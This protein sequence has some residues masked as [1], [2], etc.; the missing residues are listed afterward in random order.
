[1]ENIRFNKYC[2]DIS[3]DDS[4]S[5][6]DE[7]VECAL[8]QAESMPNIAKTIE[9]AQR[10][11]EKKFAKTIKK[12]AK[13]AKSGDENKNRK[14]LKISCSAPSGNI[15]S[16]STSLDNQL[17]PASGY[18]TV[19]TASPDLISPEIVITN[20]L[21]TETT[22]LSNEKTYKIYSEHNPDTSN[23]P[24]DDNCSVIPP[25]RDYTSTI[26]ESK[27]FDLP[28]SANA[29]GSKSDDLPMN[30]LNHVNSAPLPLP[31]AAIKHEQSVLADIAS[32]NDNYVNNKLCKCVICE[33]CKYKSGLLKNSEN[34]TTMTNKQSNTPT[35]CKCNIEKGCNAHRKKTSIPNLSTPPS[36]DS[37]VFSRTRAKKALRQQRRFEEHLRKKNGQGIITTPTS[38]DSSFNGTGTSSTIKPK[39]I[40]LKH[41]VSGGLLNSTTLVNSEGKAMMQTT[42]P[43]CS[44]Y[45]VEENKEVTVQSPNVHVNDPTPGHSTPLQKIDSAS[46]FDD[47]DRHSSPGGLSD[48]SSNTSINVTYMQQCIVRKSAT[49]VF[50]FPLDGENSCPEENCDFVTKCRNWHGLVDELK[51]HIIIDHSIQITATSKFCNYCSSKVRNPIK[52]HAC[53][54]AHPAI[55][56][57]PPTSASVQKDKNRE[58]INPENKENIIN[59]P[60]S[61]TS[62]LENEDPVY[63]S[64][65]PTCMNTSSVDD[66]STTRAKVPNRLPSQEMQTH[67]DSP[68]PSADPPTEPLTPAND[69]ILVPETQEEKHSQPEGDTQS[70]KQPASSLSMTC[71]DTPDHATSHIPVN[72]AASPIAK[73]L[74]EINV[75]HNPMSTKEKQAHLTFPGRITRSGQTLHLV[76]P[77]TE[78]LQCTEGTCSKTFPER[79]WFRERIKLVDHLNAS[80]NTSI[81]QV[82]RWCSIC[83]LQVPAKV[84][85]HPCFK[86]TEFFTP[87][88]DDNMAPVKTTTYMASRPS[89]NNLNHFDNDRTRNTAPRFNPLPEILAATSNTLTAAESGIPAQLTNTDYVNIY[90]PSRST[91]DEVILNISDNSLED[92]EIQ[93]PVLLQMAPQDNGENTPSITVPESRDEIPY[94]SRNGNVINFVFPITSG[95]PCTDLGCPFGIT[96]NAWRYAREGIIQ[97]L[98]V[99]HKITN[100]ITKYWC[101]FCHHQIKGNLSEHPCFNNLCFY[102]IAEPDVKGD[103]PPFSCRK[104]KYKSSVKNDI[105]AHCNAHNAPTQSSGT[106]DLDQVVQLLNA[107]G[108][109]QADPNNVHSLPI[110]NKRYGDIVHLVFPLPSSL[111]CTETHTDCKQ[112]FTNKNWF[113]SKASLVRHLQQFHKL[114]INEVIGWCSHC[115][116]KTPTRV[117]THSCLRGG[118]TL[119]R[120]ANSKQ[121]FKCNKCDFSCSSKNGIMNHYRTHRRENH[122]NIRDHLIIR[123]R[124]DANRVPALPPPADLSQVPGS[125]P[126]DDT[127]PNSQPVPVSQD[128]GE[129]GG[130][131]DEEYEPNNTEINP[132]TTDDNVLPG[133]TEDDVTDPDRPSPSQEYIN[134]FQ[135]ILDNWDGFSWEQ[136]EAKLEAF[137]EFGQKHVNLKAWSEGYIKPPPPNPKDPRV[138]QKLYRNNRRRAIRLITENDTP[139]CNLTSDEITNHFCPPP[140][141]D[142]SP[143]FF[144]HPAPAQTPPSCDPFHP[145]EV[146]DRLRAAEN[147]S[148]GPDRLT[149][150]HLKKIDPGA[151]ALA[152]IFSICLKAHRVPAIWKVSRTVLIAKC[153][154][155]TTPSDWRPISLNN[156]SMKLFTGCLAKRITNWIETNNILT[157]NQKGFLPYDGCFENNYIINQLIQ[158]TRQHR[159]SLCLASLDISNAFGSVPHGAV[160]EAIRQAGIGDTYL[161]TVISLYTESS[162]TFLLEDGTSEPT[163]FRS[164]VRQGCPLSGLL[165]NFAIDPI[166]RHIQGEHPSYKALAYADDIILI[167]NDPESLQ[168]SISTATALAAEIGLNINPHKC[169]TIHFA[170]SPMG[171]K[172]TKF[173]VNDTTLP[174]ILDGN[175]ARFLG[176]PIGFNLAPDVQHFDKFVTLGEEV[177]QSKLAPWQSLDALKSFVYPSYLYAMRTGQYL[178]GDWNELDRH[179]RPHIKKTLSLPTRAANEYLYGSVEQGLFNIPLCAED[180]DIANIDGAFKLL[181]SKD[182]RTK[183]L[184]W[185]DIAQFIQDRIGEVPSFNQV[186]SFLSGAQLLG[187]TNPISTMWSRARAASTRLRVTW[188]VINQ[189]DVTLSFGDQS[190]KDRTEVFRALRKHFRLKRGDS[191]AAK[192]HQGKTFHCYS[193]S[194]S[195]THFHRAGD[196]TRFA[197]WRFIHAARLGLVPLNGY[198]SADDQLSSACRRCPYAQETLP[199]VICHCLTHMPEITARHNN[200]VERIKNAALGRWQLYSE[201]RPLAGHTVRPDLVLTKGNTALILDVTCPF[202]NGPNAFDVARAEK[203]RK[204]TPLASSLAERFDKVKV[205]AIVVGALGSWDPNND[206]VL[207]S[208]CSK[209]YLKL[210]R[211]LIVSTTIRATRNIYIKHISG[212]PQDDPSA[213]PPRSRY[214]RRRAPPAFNGRLNTT[215][216]DDLHHT[217]NAHASE[218]NSTR[219]QAIEFIDSTIADANNPEASMPLLEDLLTSH[220]PRSS[221]DLRD[222]I[223]PPIM[224]E[225]LRYLLD[226]GISINELRSLIAED[227]VNHPTMV[228]TKRIL[229]SNENLQ[230]ISNFSKTISN[231]SPTHATSMATA[232]VPTRNDNVH[233]NTNITVNSVNNK[234]SVSANAQSVT[235]NVYLPNP[236]LA[237]VPMTI[238]NTST[239]TA[240]VNT[241]T[242][243]ASVNTSTVTASVYSNANRYSI[244]A[245]VTIASESVCNVTSTCALSTMTSSTS[246]KLNLNSDNLDNTN[247]IHR[248]NRAQISPPPG[249][250]SITGSYNGL[251]PF[252]PCGNLANNVS[253]PSQIPTHKSPEAGSSA[254]GNV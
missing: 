221:Q 193:M 63:G 113:T 169:C 43:T 150:N 111:P 17:Q 139:R 70:V 101:T 141:P 206:A 24:V 165:F 3:S 216:D 233:N 168:E 118:T 175:F 130:D 89:G 36:G 95:L 61:L 75:S 128:V 161:Q 119:P 202:E 68:Q 26:A 188:Q 152:R 9:R 133:T 218:T 13:N 14:N 151:L 210:M 145:K 78:H 49:L 158:N 32:T 184:A 174:S 106:N 207:A 242:V 143:D 8:R 170:G 47:L 204:Y 186:A 181:T 241:S 148:P 250:A 209:K 65:R 1:M 124:N 22:G 195:S 33:T 142:P 48:A 28:T 173:K 99:R 176:K 131:D 87:T 180:S 57:P 217:D 45:T 196:F 136:F 74:H 190:T 10:R 234:P 235:A 122:E 171:C 39:P 226:S 251:P 105:L 15:D 38:K 227:P 237:R 79:S 191:L 81:T 109:S 44:L 203:I 125:P 31:N 189:D 69:E 249:F 86:N 96:S 135:N 211:K 231:D 254:S 104:C 5:S 144:A 115:G 73:P 146:W 236:V 29:S 243:T 215:P 80:H 238:V 244:T 41:F 91:T 35:M 21:T 103:P 82:R 18:T 123:R 110:G 182:P 252:T 100:P 153:E 93:H 30:G 20:P 159:D 23:I 92:F 162:T 107:E 117:A 212:I 71:P 154:Q 224:V 177:L 138:I 198:R 56:G 85:S 239:V 228:P 225:D 83:H 219:E 160:F 97:H 66:L 246:Q 34:V 77:I 112:T 94:Y 64:P 137:V 155:P 134:Y 157:Y 164:G 132:A 84:A 52:K 229:N 147:T 50:R 167:E 129:N 72:T 51:N 208:I 37:P 214:G 88:L 220:P 58:T 223:N 156:T 187:T 4:S 213:P 40:A 232:N 245:P 98:L 27:T 140:A 67:A 166:L 248:A 59:Q 230:A 179:F 222:L 197:E 201:N 55:L 42:T 16:G 172:D 185:C 178:K 247:Y 183:H 102:K 25:E 54:K 62:Q 2:I 194:P 127:P 6:E 199:H 116:Q 7:I 108:E 60:N 240:S 53:F 126:V 205:E 192:P 46:F 163:P 114:T 200:I 120:P 12:R 76:F 19:E 253:C 149:Y 90:S 121:A 11:R